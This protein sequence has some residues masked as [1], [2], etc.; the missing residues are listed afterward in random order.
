M[1]RIL[2]W[3]T[4]RITARTGKSM[5]G[6]Q[7]LITACTHQ[8]NDSPSP[9][10]HLIFSVRALPIHYLRSESFYPATFPGPIRITFARCTP[11]T[12]P[13][14]VQYLPLRKVHHPPLH[15]PSSALCGPW[16]DL[17]SNAVIGIE[18]DEMKPFPIAIPILTHTLPHSGFSQLSC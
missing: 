10:Q 17:G 5:Q 9:P 3:L 7:E 1:Q 8:S 15:F 2:A 12:S 14:E 16:S 13:S 18:I 4:A 6:C 11:S